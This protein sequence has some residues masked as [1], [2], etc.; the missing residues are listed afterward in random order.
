MLTRWVSKCSARA[1]KFDVQVLDRVDVQ[2]VA[3]EHERR[4]GRTAARGVVDDVGQL[5]PAG[6]RRARRLARSRRMSGENDMRPSGSEVA[7]RQLT[8]GFSTPADPPVDRLDDGSS[9]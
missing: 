1:R 2:V 8:S 6:T 7:V 5:E 9:S 4:H 3:R